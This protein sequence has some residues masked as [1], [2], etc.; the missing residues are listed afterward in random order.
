MLIQD[1]GSKVDTDLGRG[2]FK[3]QLAGVACRILRHCQ[4]IGNG[5]FTRHWPG[6]KEFSPW[7]FRVFSVRQTC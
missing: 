4:S 1:I 6:R 7:T 3:L 2:G 5:M